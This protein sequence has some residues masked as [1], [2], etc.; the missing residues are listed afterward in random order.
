MVPCFRPYRTEKILIPL[1]AKSGNKIPP[2]LNPKI[3]LF[4]PARQKT[5]DFSLDN[6]PLSGVYW[7]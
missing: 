7:N 6:P 3:P 1:F 4:R 5:S 2:E